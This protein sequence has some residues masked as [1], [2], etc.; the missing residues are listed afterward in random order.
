MLC[1]HFSITCPVACLRYDLWTAHSLQARKAYAKE[2]F[3]KRKVATRAICFRCLEPIAV[4]RHAEKAA[5]SLPR[6]HR[7][8]TAAM[9]AL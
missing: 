7:I 9:T 6:V 4:V 2:R 5:E 1:F 3:I 8:T